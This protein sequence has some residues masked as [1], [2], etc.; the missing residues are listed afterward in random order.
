MKW[1]QARWQ[2][3]R[4]FLRRNLPF[5][6]LAGLIFTL[7]VAFELPKMVVVIRSGEVGVEYKLFNQGTV[8]DYLYPEGV[9]LV[10]PWNTIFIYN[11]RIQESKEVLS[12]LTNDGLDVE[13]DLSIRYHP[14]TT[15]IGVLHQTVGPDYVHTIAIPEV[16]SAVRTTVSTMT[17]EQ[18]YT[19]GLHAASTTQSSTSAASSQPNTATVTA[20][21]QAPNVEEV[22][23][24]REDTTLIGA[25]NK[26]VD[27]AAKKYVLIDN[28]IVTRIKIPDSVQAAIQNKV[29]QQQLAEAGKFRIQQSV[30]EAQRNTTLNQG[31]TPQLLQLRGI[32]ATEKLATSPN[33][34]VII[35]GNGPN[36]LPVILGSN[37]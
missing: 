4:E 10:W 35:V 32:E 29:T 5:L 24:N 36:S 31:L 2:R 28:V 25:I 14:E 30:Y 1:I 12:V 13:I 6:I 33:S 21:L 11:T 34:K 23:A 17:I 20:P 26:A 7:V 15:M 3:F 37:P 27:Q 18:L 8:T 22:I 9:H 16:E 19:G